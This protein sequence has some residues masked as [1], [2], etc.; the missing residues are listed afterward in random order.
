MTEFIDIAL[1]D[2]IIAVTP[3]GI[4]IASVVSHPHGVQHGLGRN[5]AALSGGALLA[6]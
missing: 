2:L 6:R 1:S 4:K 5:G 3:Y